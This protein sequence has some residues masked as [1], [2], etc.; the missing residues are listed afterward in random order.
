MH[1]DYG[2]KLQLHSRR[3]LVDQFKGNLR[4]FDMFLIIYLDIV[5]SQTITKVKLQR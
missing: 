1:I 4:S 3:I 5:V 2:L